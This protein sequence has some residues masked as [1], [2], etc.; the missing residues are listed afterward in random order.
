MFGDEVVR[1]AITLALDKDA[2]SESIYGGLYEKADT[3]FP[4]TLPYCDVEQTVYSYDIDRANQLL[5]E[6]GYID[7]DGDGIREKDGEKLSSPFQYQAGS[8]SDDNLVVYIC[9]QLGKIGIELIPQS[10]QMMDWYAM[11]TTGRSALLPVPRIVCLW[12]M[13]LPS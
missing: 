12:C 11:I 5:D 1:Q 9:D 6:A 8:A 7:T 2:I 10:A 13:D 3:F 4:K